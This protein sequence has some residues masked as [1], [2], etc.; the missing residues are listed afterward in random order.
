C[1]AMISGNDT[2]G[3]NDIHST[4]TG[5]AP[6]TGTNKPLIGGPPLSPIALMD[7][8]D[9][10][11]RVSELIE[12]HELLIKGQ[13]EESLPLLDAD[14]IR[15][16]RN[17]VNDHEGMSLLIRAFEEHPTLLHKIRTTGIIKGSLRKVEA[18]LPTTPKLH[19]PSL[20]TQPSQIES[21]IN[22]PSDV[23]IVR[24][25]T[26][27]PE[28]ITMKEM[29][30]DLV[31]LLAGNAPVIPQ[32]NNHLFSSDLIPKAVHVTVGATGLSPY[33]RANKIFS[34]VLAT[35][36]CHSNPNSVFSSL[37]ISLQK[38]GLKNMASKLMEKLSEYKH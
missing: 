12:F 36:E 20:A 4:A 13:V 34:S 37:I 23:P 24:K 15:K 10:R 28:Y 17:A 22:T 14:T 3:T 16:I 27:S 38:V 29:L 19:R 18:P 32:L 21:T 5:A 6:P 35:I 11:P 30:A 8:P 25:G 2:K 33:D 1:N 9:D 26:Q 31:D 7:I